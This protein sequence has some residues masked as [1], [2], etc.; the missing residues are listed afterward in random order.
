MFED[1]IKEKQKKGWKF[2]FK[3]VDKSD[4]RI[5]KAYEK[6]QKKEFDRNAAIKRI[7]KYAKSL[8]W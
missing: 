4:Q 2:D 3:K 8:D 5:I 6:I 7:I 1:L